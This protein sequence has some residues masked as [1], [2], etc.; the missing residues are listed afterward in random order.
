MS[1]TQVRVLVAFLTG[2]ARVLKH[3]KYMKL[4]STDV[5]RICGWEEETAEHILCYCGGLE[6]RRR[7]YF[8]SLDG[9]M[10]PTELFG[11]TLHNIY[12]FLKGIEIVKEEYN[13]G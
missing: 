12:D 9:K 2:H 7:R 6:V 10:N 13:L 4:S 3:L 11:Y 1:V 8:G 5:C